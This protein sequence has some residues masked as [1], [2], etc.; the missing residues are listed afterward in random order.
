MKKPNETKNRLSKATARQSSISV[1][2]GEAVAEAEIRGLLEAR[3]TAV[4]AKDVAGATTNVAHDVVVF[5]VVD[6]FQQVGIEAM[7][8]R[9]SSWFSSFEDAIGVEVH[10]L[11][12]AVSGDAAF[13]HSL[14]RYFGKL[15]SG[16]TLDM[17]VRVTLCLR[18]INGQ[19][20]ITHEHNSVPFDSKSGTAVISPNI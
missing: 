4:R 16:R 1:S 7:R 8:E 9:A 14:N 3:I 6:A 5:D 19:W 12:V 13:A 20:L 10:D 15:R 2:E 11:T 18:K 17:C